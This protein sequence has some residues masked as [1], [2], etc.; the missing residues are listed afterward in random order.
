M[1]NH[2]DLIY[3]CCFGGILGIA[4]IIGSNFTDKKLIND[5]SDIYN[6]DEDKNEELNNEIN[7]KEV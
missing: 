7:K 6:V 2:S 5:D 4:I 3:S 1:E